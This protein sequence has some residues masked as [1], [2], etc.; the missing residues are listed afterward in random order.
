MYGSMM[1]CWKDTFIKYPQ[2]QNKPPY[3]SEDWQWTLDI[4]GG[5]FKNI[6]IPN[7]VHY[8]RQDFISK[9]SLL[10]SQS[11]YRAML[12]PTKLLSYEHLKSVNI[13]NDNT[14][15][16]NDKGFKLKLKRR[17][18]DLL[19]YANTFKTYT[20]VKNKIKKDTEIS[21]INLPP[22][23]IKDW[24]DINKLE[25]IIFPSEYILTSASRW[26]P[27]PEVSEK[28]IR[29]N[30]QFSKKPDT[31]FFVPW[32]IRGGADKVFIN[33][34]NQIQKDHPSWKMSMIQTVK[35][36]SIW[37]DRLD[38]KIDFINLDK[39]LGALEYE[40]QMRL[41]ATFVVQNNIKRIIIGNSRFAY[42]FIQ[43]YKKLVTTQNIKVYAFA[44][45]EMINLDGRIGDYI[46][47]KLPLIQDCTYRIITDNTNTVSQL[48]DEHA[49]SKDK[50]F[51][52]HQYLDNQIKKPKVRQAKD[53]KIMW[54]SRITGQKTPE[55]L[56]DIGRR[57]GNK[58]QID[59][60]GVFEPP[61]NE[62]F[63]EGSNLNYV[64][65]FDGINDLPTEKYDVFLY[66]S[67]ADGM[68][69]MLLEIASKGLPIITPDIGGVTDF[70]KD[71][72]TG[73]VVD[74]YKDVD[75]FIG[76]IK[77][78]ENYDLR[79]KLAQN[80]QSLLKTEFTEEKWKN[81]VKEIFDK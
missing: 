9:P 1:M 33:T 11:S 42:D 37:Q 68:P 7:S 55:V 8:Y 73:L 53:I 23:V 77:E 20:A 19:T 51:V 30:H 70:I 17:V 59:L 27:N 63:F 38:K 6:V 57:I 52:H 10:A 76:Y 16:I 36:D 43:R 44:F 47:E 48:Y 72:K 35:K 25:K 60:Y 54:A 61:Y 5:G 46:H 22:E 3:G 26:S 13:Q 75:S 2:R 79:Q 31:L 29:F 67:N 69:N 21:S 39:S 4:M 78:M 81:G 45:T 66:T 28:Y 15:K 18:Y 65:T 71:H 32:L 40:T 50:I 80:A 41:T 12:S 34:A 24:K 62:E 56:R 58:Y 49:I 14:V 64:R 74:E